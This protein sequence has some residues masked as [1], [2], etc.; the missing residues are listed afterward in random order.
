MERG[1]IVYLS[2]YGLNEKPFSLTP[3]TKF[4]YLSKNHQ[5]ALNHLVYGIR[6]KEGF[7]VLTGDVGT[8]KTTIVRA[9]LERLGEDTSNALILNPMLEGEDL[10]RAILEEFRIG[11]EGARKKALLDRLNQFLL[12]ELMRGRNAVLVIDEAQDL[13]DQALEEIR[14]LSNLETEKAKLLQII[15]VGQVEL[16]QKL[17][18]SFL[19]PLN[20]RISIRYHLM[21]LSRIDTEKY[22][23]HRL[24]VAGSNG[25]LNFSDGALSE[26]FKY[27]RGVP[28]LINLICDRTLL[29]GYAKQSNYLDKQIVERGAGSLKKQGLH[30]PN[31]SKSRRFLLLAALALLL[32]C[33]FLIV[34]QGDIPYVESSKSAHFVRM[35]IPVIERL[36]PATFT[37]GIGFTTTPT[38]EGTSP[39][40]VTG[41]EE[42]SHPYSIQI[43]SYRDNSRA[44]MDVN[45][46][47]KLGYQAFI[48]KA[49]LPDKGI[50]YQ[51]MFG[52]FQ[53]KADAQVMLKKIKTIKGFSDARIIRVKGGK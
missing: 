10:L 37:G 50:W 21:R 3:D 44:F 51:V 9:L 1:K 11:N 5:D 45:Q 46:L 34:F 13:S 25:N 30:A 20:Q 33:T 14:L 4:L 8:G 23:L 32:G 26:I 18:S 19:R 7:V 24:L 15:L 39:P 43:R 12:M 40:G 49:E 2:F 47:G 53:T 17:E 36:S 48:M 38:H 29:A 52:R 28:R 16:H 31:S 27:S 42:L 22:I 41:A 35:R 6:E